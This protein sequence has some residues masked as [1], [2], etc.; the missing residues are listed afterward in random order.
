MFAAAA[1][2]QRSAAAVV[3][4]LVS[5]VAVAIALKP[6]WL[7]RRRSARPPVAGTRFRILTLNLGGNAAAPEVAKVERTVATV[8]ADIVALQE[9]TPET[10][11]RLRDSLAD[12]Y[13]YCNGGWPAIVF[14]RLPIRAGAPLRFPTRGSDAQRVE[15]DIA[16]GTLV[17]FNVHITRPGHELHGRLAPL[18]LLLDYDPTT[19]DMDTDLVCAQAGRAPGACVVVGDLNA[20]EWSYPH[21]LLSTTLVDAFREAARGWGNTYRLALWVG[22]WR[23]HLPVARIDYVFH[24]RDLVTLEAAVGPDS[25]SDHL[26]VVADLAFR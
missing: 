20:T 11:A 12:R 21:R 3:L 8:D 26:P 5:F 18:R 16:G 6:T 2:V 23:L 14:S 15:I 1:A 19:R 10:L 13:A 4:A 9:L 7:V 24:S 25:G 22:R 17:L